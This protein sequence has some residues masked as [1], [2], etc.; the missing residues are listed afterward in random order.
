[1]PDACIAKFETSQNSSENIAMNG[2]KDIRYL[3][4]LLPYY[5]FS[6]SYGYFI[7]E[8]F[9]TDEGPNSRC[10]GVRVSEEM[11]ADSQDSLLDRGQFL[12]YI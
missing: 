2:R 6:V 3:D 7:R 9:G 1:M 10:M 4:T 8:S 11:R 5:P 12:D